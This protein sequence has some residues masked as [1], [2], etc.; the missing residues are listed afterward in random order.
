MN[1]HYN[2]TFVFESKTVRKFKLS[3]SL[4]KIILNKKGKDTKII[5]ILEYNFKSKIDEKYYSNWCSKRYWF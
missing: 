2:S 5:N 3:G 1:L 4:F